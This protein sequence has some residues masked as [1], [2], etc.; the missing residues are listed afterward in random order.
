[1]QGGRSFLHPDS[2]C[3]NPFTN[4]YLTGSGIPRNAEQDPRITATKSTILFPSLLQSITWKTGFIL[5]RRA[6]SKSSNRCRFTTASCSGWGPVCF[7]HL[8]SSCQSSSTIQMMEERQRR[9]LSS[10]KLPGANVAK[11]SKAEP[12]SRYSGRLKCHCAT[13]KSIAAGIR[14]S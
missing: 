12:F 2:P 8:G 6:G 9:A 13:R 14:F 5:L 7:Y 4:F 10:R 3:M 11:P 1:M